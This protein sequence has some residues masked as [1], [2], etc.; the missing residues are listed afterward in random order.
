[1]RLGTLELMHKDAYVAVATAGDVVGHPTLLTGLAPEFTVRARED[2]LLYCL[3]RDA[4]IDLLSRPAGIQWMA[5]DSRERLLQAAG[6]MRAMPDVRTLP[7]TSVTRSKPLFCDPETTAQEA[8]KI[9]D[10]REALGDP[11]ARPRRQGHRRHRHRRR[12]AQQGRRRRRLA[13]RPG[14]RDHVGAGAHHRRRGPRPG[15]EHRDDGRRREPHA[16]AGRRRR[17]GRRPVRQQPDDARV[18]QPVR[19]A[20][21]DHGGAQR[22]RGG[23]GRRRH[24]QAVRRP[25]DG[26]HGRALGDPRAHRAA[27]LAH[28]AVPRAHHRPAGRAAGAVRLARLR[29]RRPVGAHARLRPGQRTRLR[30]HRRPRRGGLLPRA[31]AGRQRR[32]RALR[33]ALRPARRARPAQ[34]VAHD[35][36]AVEGGLRG[37]PRRQGPRPPGA[38][39][40]RLRLPA[41]RRRALRRQGAHRRAPPGA[42]T[43]G[44]S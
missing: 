18:A 41:D 9:T 25:D 19:P 34:R 38:R 7:V 40:R 28:G 39:Q 11:G 6:T 37:L 17:G 27:R 35:A 36:V 20:P 42:R 21:R 30:R 10:R 16:G 43:T 8:A 15:G 24:P 4:A 23:Q 26:A 12:P 1:M 13:A 3:P 2:S 29:Q 14:H 44:A 32:A 5:A 33:A 22:G 31:R